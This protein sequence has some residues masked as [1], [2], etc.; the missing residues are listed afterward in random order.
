ML[1]VDKVSRYSLETYQTHPKMDVIN[2]NYQG[3]ESSFSKSMTLDEAKRFSRELQ[4]LIAEFEPM[5]A[6][7]G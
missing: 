4:E 3:D 6:S 2:I 1:T 7:H 5:E